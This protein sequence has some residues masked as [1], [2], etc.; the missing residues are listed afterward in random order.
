[1][2]SF[3]TARKCWFQDQEPVE[4][5]EN[6]RM[7]HLLWRTSSWELLS[8]DAKYFRRP[9]LTT[10]CRFQLLVN[11]GLDVLSQIERSRLLVSTASA[12]RLYF[13]SPGEDQASAVTVLADISSPMD[14]TR[15]LEGGINGRSCS[16]NTL[17]RTRIPCQSE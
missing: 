7:R 14:Q 4:T 5:H 15:K 8:R 11:S 17:V 2:K 13:A 16:V 1:M 3:D 12:G 10:T 6:E 9:W